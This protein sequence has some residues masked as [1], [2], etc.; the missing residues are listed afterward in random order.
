MLNACEAAQT[1]PQDPLAGVA[2]SLMEYGVPAVVAMQL[3]ITGDGAL[4]LTL[5][6]ISVALILAL[7]AVIYAKLAFGG[8]PHG[9]ELTGF[10][11]VP[12]GVSLST[13]ALVSRITRIPHLR[14]WKFPTLRGCVE[15]RP[16]GL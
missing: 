16:E 9:L 15:A 8:A 13:V 12:D 3:A 6:L 11:D 1:A 7:V 2:T 10:V 4:G 5:E 14:S